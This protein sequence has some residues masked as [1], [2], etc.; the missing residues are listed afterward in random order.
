M[1]FNFTKDDIEKINKIIGNP[2]QQNTDNWVWKIKNENTQQNLIFTIYN[3]IDL[4][5]EV[6]GSLI[7]AQTQHGYFEIHDCKAYL[8][9]EPDEVIFITADNKYVSCMIIGKQGTCS[10]FTNIRRELL[11]SN[12]SELN[13]AV[14]LSAMQLSLAESIVMDLN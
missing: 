10:M 12:F 2:I 7:S 8:I 11:H 9:F 6:K 1:A 3:N 4:S 13:P 14:L 5:D